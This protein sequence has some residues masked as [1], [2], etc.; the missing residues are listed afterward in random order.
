M[1]FHHPAKI[2]GRTRNKKR[3]IMMFWI[4]VV[5]QYCVL[6]IIRAFAILLRFWGRVQVET[7]HSDNGEGRME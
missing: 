4:E 2:D 3:S 1:P 6:A 7:S 5:N